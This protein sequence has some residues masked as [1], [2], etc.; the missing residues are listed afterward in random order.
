[1]DLLNEIRDKAMRVAETLN[2]PR[3]APRH[4]LLA[5]I[6]DG[7]QAVELLRGEGVDPQGL[8]EVLIKYG[9]QEGELRTGQ[10]IGPAAS[11]IILHTE[12]LAKHFREEAGPE[13]LL[14]ALSEDKEFLNDELLQAI[15]IDWAE[16][17]EAMRRRVEARHALHPSWSQ[18]L[19]ADLG[20]HKV[21][22]HKSFSDE[23]KDS[24]KAAFNAIRERGGGQVT[25]LDILTALIEGDEGRQV[26]KVLSGA[27]FNME[28][29]KSSLGYAEDTL[30]S[31]R[32]GG[33]GFA[34]TLIDALYEAKEQLKAFQGDR[35]EWHHLLLGLLRVGEKVYPEIFGEYADVPYGAYQHAAI[36]LIHIRRGTPKL[37]L[38]LELEPKAFKLLTQ[39]RMQEFRV[40]PVGI[41]GGKLIVGTPG[42]LSP[43]ILERIEHAVG[44]PV[45]ARLAPGKWFKKHAGL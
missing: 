7:G 11:S 14:W 40:I 26:E 10:V 30:E 17:G 22:V 1:M 42:Y 35:V 34:G 32:G 20:L 15:G 25:I 29:L 4:L 19:I 9:R 37:D 44:M 3:V 33:V 16:V 23:A 39:S 41:I 43:H 24:L 38:K 36:E 12:E 45:E 13:F 27:G 21:D 8:E 18:A 6:A 31:T 28:G 5:L 2:A